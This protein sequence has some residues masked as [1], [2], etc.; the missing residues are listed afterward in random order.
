MTDLVSKKEGEGFAAVEAKI[1]EK[2][3]ARRESFHLD[4]SLERRKI[5][6]KLLDGVFRVPDKRKRRS[7]KSSPTGRC[8]L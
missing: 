6:E 2:I 7:A 4:L 8:D 3:Y 1:R 5:A